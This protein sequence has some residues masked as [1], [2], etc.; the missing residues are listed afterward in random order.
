MANFVDHSPIALSFA[1]HTDD[2]VNSSLFLRSKEDPL[3]NDKSHYYNG[4]FH[5]FFNDNSWMLSGKFTPTSSA[6]NSYIT[7][8]ALPEGPHNWNSKSLLDR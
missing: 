2:H 3:A 1:G 7:A 8:S 6:C 5:L 4:K